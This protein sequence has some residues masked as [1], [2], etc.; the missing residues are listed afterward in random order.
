MWNLFPF[1]LLW[2]FIYE[3]IFLFANSLLYP[4]N[5]FDTLLLVSHSISELCHFWF[6]LLFHR[7]IVFLFSFNF[8]LLCNRFH[9][10]FK[11]FVIFFC[12]PFI[13][14]WYVIWFIPLFPYNIIVKGLNT[15]FFYC[16][17][18]NKVGFPVL[19]KE[20]S[21]VG[22]GQTRAAF[23]TSLFEDYLSALIQKQD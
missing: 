23:L 19:L 12:H 9:L 22:N 13:I 14:C 11:Y 6:V 20:G 4:E 2:I 8:I 7:F 3:M 1:V 10:F 16:S 21:C 17:C 5:S 18:L 15:I